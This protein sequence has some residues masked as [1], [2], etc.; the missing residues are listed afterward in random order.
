MVLVVALLAVASVA[1]YL[2]ATS[3]W[4]SF[5]EVVEPSMCPV[6]GKTAP[7]KARKGRAHT[8]CP[9]CGAW[10]RHRLLV[11]YL[12]QHEELLAP[13]RRVLHF[14]PNKGVEAFM[15]R[16]KG[17]HYVTADLFT[18]A[19]LQ[20]DLSAID[21]P[22]GSWD[23]VLCYHVLEH[24]PDDAAAM[25][26]LFRVLAPGG[27]A[28]VQVPLQRGSVATHEDPSIVD[29]AERLEHFGQE[30]HVRKYGAEDFRDRL[31]AAGFEVH[32]I[33]H[34]AALSEQTLAKHRMRREPDGGP[35]WDERIWVATK[36]KAP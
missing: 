28:I 14:A 9:N 22:D 29:P 6:C 25:R 34:A 13:G 30:D 8:E 20:L 16:R 4:F 17:L 10:E 32:A 3:H 27:S 11:H 31:E 35:A 23:L 18:P 19:D 2:H 24:V 5:D 33:A 15:R 36:P 21:Q 1:G 12:S 7:F 26:E